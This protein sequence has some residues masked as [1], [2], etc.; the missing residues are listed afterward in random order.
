MAMKRMVLPRAICTTLVGRA[1]PIMA[2]TMAQEEAIS[3]TGKARRN[4]ARLRLS[5]PGPAASA[6]ARATIRPAPRTKSR[7]NGKKPL[8]RGT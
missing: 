2:P 5:R 8:T 3:A 7:W 6:P 1:R 4:E